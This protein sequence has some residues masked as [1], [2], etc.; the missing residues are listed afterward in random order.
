MKLKDIEKIDLQNLMKLIRRAKFD[1][2]TGLEAL[3][4]TRAYNFIDNL[5]K[6]SD[7][8]PPP[9][10]QPTVAPMPQVIDETPK[11]EIIPPS[12]E[13]TPEEKPKQRKKKVK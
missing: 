3:A 12:P 2:F 9:P 8:P 7:L 13:S 11:I 5:I 6:I 1:D 10:P 4:L